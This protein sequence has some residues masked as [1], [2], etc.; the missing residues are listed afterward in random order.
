MRDVSRQGDR[1]NNS[2]HWSPPR[3]ELG[4]PRTRVQFLVQKMLPEKSQGTCSC[5]GW[6]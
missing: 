2:R 5:W 3:E 1:E 4:P 6:C